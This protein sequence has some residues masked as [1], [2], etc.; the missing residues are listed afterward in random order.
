M[1]DPDRIVSENHS[2]TVSN[3]QLVRVLESIPGF[4]EWTQSTL[5][6]WLTLWVE[7][8]DRQQLMTLMVASLLKLGEDSPPDD[9]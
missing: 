3:F 1:T 7:Q 8:A 6:E 2:S 5:P 4:D 9:Q